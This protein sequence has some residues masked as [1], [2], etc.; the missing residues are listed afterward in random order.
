MGIGKLQEPG[1]G[2]GVGEEQVKRNGTGGWG[3]GYVRDS[4]KTRNRKGKKRPRR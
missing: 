2:P 4:C 1:G 3:G